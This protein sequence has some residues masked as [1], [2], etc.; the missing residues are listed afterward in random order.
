VATR[1]PLFSVLRGECARPVFLV[2]LSLNFLSGRED[3]SEINPQMSQIKR[4]GREAGNHGCL[5]FFVCVHLRYLWMIL[6]WLRPS[7]ALCY[8]AF[9][10]IRA[11]EHNLDLSNYS[12]LTIS[13]EA[14]IS[15][16]GRGTLAVDVRSKHISQSFAGF[17]WGGYSCPTNMPD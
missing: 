1:Q 10:I 15:V 5:A 3:F 16:P 11:R 2:L 4:I 17:P 14:F 8:T 13:I 12:L 9:P 7:A 6:F